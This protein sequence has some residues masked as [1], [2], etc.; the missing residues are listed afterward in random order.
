MRACV[1]AVV[2]LPGC[3]DDKR[4]NI[5]LISV[6]SLRADRLH[7]YGNVHET[8]PNLDALAEAGARF[9]RVVAESPWT[10]PSHATMLTGVSQAVHGAGFGGQRLPDGLVTL[11][12]ALRDAG[13]RTYGVWSG[14]FLHPYFGFGQGFSDGDYI[15]ALGVTEYDAGVISTEKVEDRRRMSGEH[16]RAHAGSTSEDIADAA[17]RFLE[18][19]GDAP[20]LLFLHF[21]DVHFDYV[22]PESY[23]RRFDPDYD[24]SLDPHDYAHNKAI[25]RDLPQREIDHLLARY[26]GEIL[27]TDEQIG[28][29]LDRLDA[30]GLGDDT[31]VAVTAD[32]GEEFFEHGSK[33]HLAGVY[34]ELLLVPWI[35]RFPGRIEP[36]LTIETQARHLDVMPT[37]LD[38]V[39]LPAPDGVMG[40]SV[41]PAL[42][43]G[44]AR[45]LTAIARLRHDKAVTFTAVR[46]T[47]HKLVM[48][49]AE[50][51]QGVSAVF[52]LA[53]DPGEQ[54][55][56][57]GPAVERPREEMLALLERVSDLEESLRARLDDPG[58]LLEGLPEDVEAALRE[59]GY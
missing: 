59:M 7:C 56:R 44:E 8:S 13:Y 14:P 49:T 51:D 16:R 3:A 38:L 9:E 45:D 50:G 37:L 36:G 6:D 17:I 31:I 46:Q 33:G 24:G 55:P 15:S 32:H 12:E 11:A 53:D 43:G 48:R 19:Q 39:G 42:L 41:A 18:G 28:R 10:L 5:V 35:V 54:S 22:P 57:N 47:R 40:T 4:P 29:I 34:D 20:F 30:L 52:H 2:A 25:D 26:D 23:W 58:A 21:F 27:F 1:W